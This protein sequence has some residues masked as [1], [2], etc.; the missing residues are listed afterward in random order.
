MKPKL[1][2]ARSAPLASCGKGIMPMAK[3]RKLKKA[4]RDVL[5]C[6]HC[7]RVYVNG[8]YAQRCEHWHESWD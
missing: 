1:N 7:H 4:E 8:G 3:S 2:P 5:T 6:Q